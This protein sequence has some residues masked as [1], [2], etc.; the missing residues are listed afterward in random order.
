MNRLTILVVDDRP[1]IRN[2]L[3]LWLESDSHTVACADGGNEALKVLKKGGYDLVVTDV[4]MPEGGG[5]DLISQLR[6]DHA[7][8][9]ILAISGGGPRVKSPTALQMAQ[10]VGAHALLLKPFGRE[11]LLNAIHHL[12]EADL[13]LLE[14]AAFTSANPRAQRDRVEHRRPTTIG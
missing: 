5:V 1:E 8:V 11:Q 2:L 12:M 7:H 6:K 9:R 13:H 3:R 14:L 10:S 4:L